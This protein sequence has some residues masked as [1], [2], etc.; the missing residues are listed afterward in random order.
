MD[1]QKYLQTR[2]F[3][4]GPIDGIMGIKTQRALAMW[5]Q[6]VGLPATADINPEIWQQLLSSGVGTIG[7]GT[8]T[9]NFPSSGPARRAF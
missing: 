4:P 1:L 3:D 5:K 8:S 7:S 2:G 6:S 9:G